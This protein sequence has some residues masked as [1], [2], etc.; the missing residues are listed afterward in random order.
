MAIGLSPGCPCC[1]PCNSCSDG[2][3]NNLKFVIGGVVAGGGLL[4]CND[5]NSTFLLPLLTTNSPA[6]N[7]VWQLSLSPSLCGGIAKLKAT[8]FPSGG[9]NWIM[10]LD[11]IGSS[12]LVLVRWQTT[13]A[14]QQ[15][16]ASWLNVSMAPVLTQFETCNRINSS[17]LMSAA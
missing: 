17:C 10:Q 6:L 5:Y 16:C 11:G 7:C 4:C 14:S 13:F 8:L 12:G 2:V 1:K 15:D 3:P 9:T